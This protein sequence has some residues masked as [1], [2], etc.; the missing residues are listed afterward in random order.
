MSL[1]N[2]KGEEKFIVAAFPLACGKRSLSKLTPTI[3][4]YTVRLVGDDMIWMIF[5]KETNE[6]RVINPQAESF[7]FSCCSLG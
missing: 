7:D 4:G 3:P 5:H 6:L 1:T 2:L